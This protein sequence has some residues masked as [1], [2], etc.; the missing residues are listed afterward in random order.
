MPAPSRRAASTKAG[1]ENTARTTGDV[2]PF[3]SDPFAPD[4]DSM[5]ILRDALW[6]T[7]WGCPGLRASCARLLPDRRLKFVAQAGS[8]K[9]PDLAST[10]L[11]LE[12]A[13]DL[14]ESLRAAE[15][16]LT[17]TDTSQ[18]TRTA[19]LHRAF[20]ELRMGAVLAWPLRRQGEL[21]G[22]IALDAPRSHSWTTRHTDALARLEPLAALALR[23]EELEVQARQ[24]N[25]TLDDHER[26]VGA[27]R[28]I[29]D[30]VLHDARLLNRL[31]AAPVSAQPQVAAAVQDLMAEIL[32]ELG[33]VQDGT[34]ASG[35]P[36]EV[37]LEQVIT[38]VVP[39]LQAVMGPHGEIAYRGAGQP[40]TVRGSSL[41]LARL[42]LNLVHHARSAEPPGHQLALELRHEEQGPSIHLWGSGLGL[43]P[44][45]RSL[46][47]EAGSVM[48]ELGPNL[49][50]V[51]SQLL[52]QGA[53]LEVAGDPQRGAQ[54]R[55]TFTNP[56]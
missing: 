17:V 19:P 47:Q 56:D 46:C 42:I 34:L 41:G 4:A 55:I 22:M 53:R 18:D 14:L 13:P 36:G 15:G 51:R 52:L 6:E 31:R 16:P 38:R 9:L 29:V 48:A 12:R 30:G 11:S 54:L 32:D 49:W 8:D 35:A 50:Q 7:V 24:S 1:A 39:V 44:A 40:T 45:L 26:R 10:K 2:E 23:N 28:G 37:D 25:T 43:S 21:M 3:S 33:A 5:A 27:M 20:D